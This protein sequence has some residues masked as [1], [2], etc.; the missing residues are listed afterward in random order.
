MLI[1]MMAQATRLEPAWEFDPY[2]I[3][4]DLTSKYGIPE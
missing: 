2:N 1:P 4:Q 3:L